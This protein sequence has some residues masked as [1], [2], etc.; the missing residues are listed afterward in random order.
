MLVG[1]Q[2]RLRQSQRLSAVGLLGCIVAEVI[3]VVI[4]IKSVGYGDARLAYVGLSAF[5]IVLTAAM[6]SVLCRTP[7]L[8]PVGILM[9]PAALFALD[10]YVIAHFLVPSEGS[11]AALC[12]GIGRT[13]D[14]LIEPSKESERTPRS[15]GPQRSIEK[16]AG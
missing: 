9:W 3:A 7:L 16:G 15:R 8:E 2:W 14:D 5:A 6:G 13:D 12:P 10:M 11:N 4:V 1:R